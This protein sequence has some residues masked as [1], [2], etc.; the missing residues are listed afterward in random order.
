MPK[1]KP[2]VPSDFEKVLAE[3]I[4]K[5][6]PGRVSF[7]KTK[8]MFEHHAT[9]YALE[10]VTR[11]TTIT[12]YND[13]LE[14][15]LHVGLEDLSSGDEDPIRPAWHRVSRFHREVVIRTL[16][17]IVAKHMARAAKARLGAKTDGGEYA[18]ADAFHAALSQLWTVDDRDMQGEL[19]PDTPKLDEPPEPIHVAKPK[20][21][22]STVPQ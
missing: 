4:E 18:I 9:G 1:R 17:S 22:P 19:L 21:R 2:R 8:P 11:A 3:L 5:A 16:E 13:D 15:S 12:I 7:S 6:S 20:K 10:L 14:D